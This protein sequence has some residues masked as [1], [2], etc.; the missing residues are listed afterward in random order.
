MV[1]N[2]QAGRLAADHLLSLGLKSLFF[3]GWSDQWYSH[4]RNLGFTARCAEAGASSGQYLCPSL[5]RPEQNWLSRIS[6]VTEWLRELPRPVGIFAVQDY[7]AQFLME[8]CQEARLRVPQ[9]IAIIGMDNDVTVCECVEP[10]LSSISRNS[11]EVGWEAAAL[12]HRMMEG[13]RE[14]IHDILIEPAGIVARRSTDFLYAADPVVQGAL[15]YMRE[16]LQAS[17]NIMAVADYLGISKRALEIRFRS[18]L[19]NSPHEYLTLLRI[20]RAQELMALPQK[21]TLKQLAVESGFGTVQ[22]FYSAFQRY[23]GQLPKLR[24]GTFRPF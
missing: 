21:R 13:E 12:L 6:K 4:Q 17:F 16:N 1:N 5:E 7:R 11:E 23:T 3:F 15:D 18:A 8:V 9:D 24:G 2:F 14:E 20:R 19:S 22:T 10:K